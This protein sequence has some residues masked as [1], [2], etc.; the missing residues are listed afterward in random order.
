MSK[1]DSSSQPP[2][3]LSDD[4]EHEKLLKDH[5]LSRVHESAP[6]DAPFRYLYI[7][8]I[9]PP[10]HY[11]ALKHLSSYYRQT[12][13]L[14]PRGQDNRTYNNHRY[15][16]TTDNNPR[17]NMLRN[18]FADREVMHA[19]VGQ[20]YLNNLDELADSLSIHEFEFEFTFT[21]ANRFQNIHL[22][23]PPKYLSFVFY[24]PNEEP[25]IE[26]QRCNATIF[27]DKY[28]QPHY[29]ARYKANSMVAFAPH[30]YSYHGNS[31]TIDRPAM[32]LFYINKEELASWNTMTKAGQDVAPYDQFKDRTQMKLEKYRLI[33]YG[34]SSDTIATERA[35]CM[36]NA[37]RGRFLHPKDR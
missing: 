21:E 31:T 2:F 27:Y 15:N 18:V 20:F 35:Q 23:I 16:F 11:A 10:D 33:E 28:A 25:E 37:P 17:I 14:Q 3:S 9:F 19:F 4:A 29:A 32:V 12:R 5:V 24:M 26:E 36:L 7:E 13:D 8:D 1:T 34:D 22:D 30:F 6:G